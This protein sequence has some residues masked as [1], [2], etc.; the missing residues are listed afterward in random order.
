MKQPRSHDI[1]VPIVVSEHV[2]LLN[3]TRVPEERVGSRF[4]TG[5]TQMNL[6][7]PVGP[8]SKGARKPAKTDRVISKE[9]RTKL[10]RLPL[11]KAGS[12]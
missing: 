7:Y 11:A 10:Q 1:S 4:G 12:L 2:N 3:G 8:K 9:L 5:N 6:E